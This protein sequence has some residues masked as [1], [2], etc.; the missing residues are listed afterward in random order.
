LADRLAGPEAAALAAHVEACVRCQQTLEELTSNADPPNGRSPT[1]GTE[2][3]ADFLRRLEQ[4]RPPGPLPLPIRGALTPRPPTER[5]TSTAGPPA[6]EGYEVLGELGRGGMGVVYK[7]RQ[8]RLNRV[9]ALKMILAGE[10]AGPE[11]LTRFRVEAEAVASLQ[12]PNV[13][14]IHEVG[15]QNGLPYFSLE[16]CPGGNLAA[17]L[18]G[19]PL[20]PRQGAQLVEALA[21]A[22]HCAHQRGIIHRDLKPANV[23]LAADGVPKITDFGLAKIVADGGEAQTQSGAI[24]G[25]PSYMAPEQ[26]SG[27]VRQVGP[28]ADVY[29]L[30]A[31]LYECLT[32]RPPF[33]AATTLETL[34]QVASQE[35]VPPRQ[36]QPQCPRDLETVCLKCLH[37]EPQRRYSSAA[38][39]TEDLERWLAGRPVRARP[40]RAWGRMLYWVKRRPLAAALMAVSVLAALALLVLTL[41]LLWNAQTQAAYQ[42]AEDARA[43]EQRQRALARRYLYAAHL[44]LAERAWQESRAERMRELLEGQMPEQTGGVDLRGFE[45]HYLWRLGRAE[46]FTVKA[47]V[48]ATS[49]AF[50]PDGRRLAAVAHTGSVKV[51]DVATG[52]ELLTLQ[53]QLGVVAS[54]A[55]RP[56]GRRL[57]TAAQGGTVQVWDGEDGREVL[58]FNAQGPLSS[59][60]YS[61]DGRRLATTGDGKMAKVWDAA[62][63][64]ELL[65]FKGHTSLVTS[66]AFSPDGRR[67]ASAD[68]SGTVK[69]WDAA[70]GRDTVPIKGHNAGVFRIVFGPDGRRLVS[71]SHDG[72]VRAW[73]AASGQEV[74]TLNLP[75]V[76][77]VAITADGRHLATAGSLQ[78]RHSSADQIHG[79]VVAV[80]DAAT[81]Q[82]VGTV[83][84]HPNN[85]L[86]LV[87]SPCGRWLT[88]ASTYGT[89][90]VWDREVSQE[91]LRLQGHTDGVQDVAFS[92]DGRRLASASW[93]GTV[94]MWDP[95]TGQNLLTLRGHTS[96]VT[97]VAFSPDGRRLASS[98]H[99]RTVKVWDV[100]LGREVLTLPAHP[101]QVYGVA[102]SPDGRSLAS[103]GGG[104]VRVWDAATGRETQILRGHSTSFQ[105]AYSPDGRRLAGGGGW[106]DQPGDVQVWDLQ[107]GQVVLSL[108][109]RPGSHYSL[110]YSPDGRWIASPAKDNAVRVWD[111]ATGQEALTLKGH[112]MNVLGVAFS[113]DSRRLASGD[114]DGT[115]KLWDLVTGQEVLTLRTPSVNNAC[116]GLSFSPDGRRLAS[117]GGDRT[118]TIW[119]ATP[120]DAKPGR[121]TGPPR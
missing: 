9:V 16:Y 1:S 101:G 85:V 93:D 62:T 117:A 107:T 12:H 67:L 69:V 71:A 113:P 90:T 74:Y 64:R 73:D 36:L 31:I 25:T 44:N 111:A 30:G 60:V 21:R 95:D 75:D 76:A 14:Q 70:T 48:H 72:T 17:R 99:D 15:D 81:G 89:L 3:E 6:V 37:K 20:P 46:H 104:A 118:V 10:H 87:F 42:Q 83:R 68:I 54:V 41:S 97:G 23:L 79:T 63:G 32:G 13:V 102:F 65:A 119:D 18:D 121:A 2:A 96:T 100:A 43:E 110:A 112:A 22:V 66:V 92:P 108:E 80:W 115:V 82:R 98:S 4:E 39:L 29:A 52:Q 84:G 7:A 8:V 33:K 27:R 78:S 59:L 116:Y 94:K 19:T 47:Y 11:R 109:R 91:P 61:P 88:C 51:W 103:A 34:Q 50:S 120:F 58:T 114:G 105:V 106:W 57:A 38:A 77:A 45:W 86:S 40:V 24:V 49:V 55:F 28:A 26:A 53:G 35:P 5:E 56:D